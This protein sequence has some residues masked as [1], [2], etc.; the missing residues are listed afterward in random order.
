MNATPELERKPAIERKEPAIEAVES[1]PSPLPQVLRERLDQV[2]EAKPNFVEQETREFATGRFGNSRINID[3]GE[4][5]PGFVISNLDIQQIT[6]LVQSGKLLSFASVGDRQFCFSGPVE[7]PTEVILAP[8]LNG[9][10]SRGLEPSITAM[11]ACWKLLFERYHFPQQK[12]SE[13]KFSFLLSE[14]L[15]SQILAAQR[16]A[17]I[18][19]NMALEEVRCTAGRLLSERGN[20]KFVIDR[21]E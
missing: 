6:E 18:R 16:E 17:A 19:A 1:K 10:S 3:R 9:F 8:N 7:A 4:E 12:R 2:R 11:Q 14:D 15:D 21:I 13:A 20:W 5:T